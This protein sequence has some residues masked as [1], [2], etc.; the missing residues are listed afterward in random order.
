MEY[1]PRK[2]KKSR[3]HLSGL[4]KS[5]SALL[6]DAPQP[7]SIT[8]ASGGTPRTAVPVT[9]YGYS[10][11]RMILS[12]IK[13]AVKERDPMYR[14]MIETRLQ[15][16]LKIKQAREAKVHA[17][18][19]AEAGTADEPLSD[20]V[21]RPKP[22]PVVACDASELLPLISWM[23]SDDSLQTTTEFDKG[24]FM[25]VDGFN[26]RLDLC[27]QVVGPSN[28][29][30]LIASLASASTAA[31]Q[32]G[33]LMIGNNIVGTPGAQAIAAAILGKTTSIKTWCKICVP[34]IKASDG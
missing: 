2:K 33:T 32:I 30:T 1:A 8:E 25:Q 12:T 15:K 13:Q 21:L 27:K 23:E 5:I 29:D 16:E 34:S 17:F 6:T 3:D 4:A 7:Q 22:E 18:E 26:G 19:S 9:G 20:N 31:S 28:V 11:Y 14:H 24:T 10:N